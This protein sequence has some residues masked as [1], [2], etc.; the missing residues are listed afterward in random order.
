MEPFVNVNANASVLRNETN[1]AVV[2]YHLNKLLASQFEKPPQEIGEAS[3]SA[4]AAATAA[5]AAAKAARANANAKA[6]AAAKA[7]AAAKAALKL[8]A[9]FPPNQEEVRKDKHV[10]EVEAEVDGDGDVV[11]K[12]QELPSGDASNGMIMVVSSP[13]GE[14]KKDEEWSVGR[15]RGRPNTE[16]GS[17]SRVVES[18]V[19]GGQGGE[20]E[21]AQ[22]PTRKRGR[23]RKH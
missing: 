15:L 3:R 14:G 22:K 11:L 23:P 6:Y 1:N 8:I 2:Y 20:K 4:A 10:A 18:S 17:S 9:S 21:D 13:S 7:V 5:A 19:S 12:D 16:V